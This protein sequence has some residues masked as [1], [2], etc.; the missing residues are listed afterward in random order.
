MASIA[1]FI[2]STAFPT[3]LRSCAATSFPS[4]HVATW[5]YDLNSFIALSKIGKYP[6]SEEIAMGSISR[7]TVRRFKG[8]EAKA[9]VLLD[10]DLE[11]FGDPTE[12][13][14]F[15]VGCSRA[16]HELEVFLLNVTQ[17]SLSTAIE[18]MAAVLGGAQ[19][20]HT[21][22]SDEA[23][24][25]PSE[26]SCAPAAPSPGC[27]P[28]RQSRSRFPWCPRSTGPF[29]PGVGRSGGGPRHYRRCNQSCV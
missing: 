9:V 26:Q 16:M 27:S 24:S 17:Q 29:D 10:V 8:L 19:S 25:L 4:A 18:A 6:V 2:A 3:R 12:R 11:R 5:I 28:G 15:Y 7:N 13:N 20:L 1:Y 21:N 22:S 14:L 23:L